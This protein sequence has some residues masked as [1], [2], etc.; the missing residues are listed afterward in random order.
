MH[1][2]FNQSA[3]I[4]NNDS[5]FYAR[6]SFKINDDSHKNTPKLNQ[7]RTKR[8]WSLSVF[9]LIL[10]WKQLHYMFN[11]LDLDPLCIAVASSP[12]FLE[13]FNLQTIYY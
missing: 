10:K 2:P 9:N 8:W 5:I 4:N 1:N 6:E 12:Q 7:V 13:I 11:R 3:T